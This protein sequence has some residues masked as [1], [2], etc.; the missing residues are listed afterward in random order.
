MNAEAR[1]Y[2]LWVGDIEAKT[3]GDGSRPTI[4]PVATS[5]AAAVPEGGKASRE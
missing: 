3:D 2:G 1:S 5:R 4:Q